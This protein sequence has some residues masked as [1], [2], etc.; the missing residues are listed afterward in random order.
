MKLGAVVCNCGARFVGDPLDD[1]PVRVRR[2]GPVMTAVAAPAVVLTAALVF[3]WWLALGGVAVVWLAARAMKLARRDPESYGGYSVAAGTLVLT[4]VSGAGLAAF[5][6]SRIP[7]YF[8]KRE[9]RELVAT[10]SA[11]WHCRSATLEDYRNKYG[12]YP[13]DEEA[14]KKLTGQA[15]P[16]DSWGNPIKYR[17][18]PDQVAGV[19]IPV[20]ELTSFELRSPGPDGKLGTADDIVM[21]D[22]VFLTPAEVAKQSLAKIPSDH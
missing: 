22:G 3:T 19:D 5:E 10:E 13:K 7:E 6:I 17:S 18:N 8:K 11:F 16:V 12:S 15:M 2:F 14:I 4:L 21:R 9:I 20:I 1:V